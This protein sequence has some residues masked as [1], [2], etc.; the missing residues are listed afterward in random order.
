M[1]FN[2]S[3]VWGIDILHIGL[4][5]EDIVFGPHLAL[6]CLSIELSFDTSAYTGSCEV[7]GSPSFKR[8]TVNRHTSVSRDVQTPQDYSKDQPAR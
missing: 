3:V 6:E 1:R 2:P 7:Q 8:K 4:R 5:L